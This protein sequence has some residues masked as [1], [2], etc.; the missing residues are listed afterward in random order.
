MPV[1]YNESGNLKETPDYVPEAL[2]LIPHSRYVVGHITWYSVLIMTGAALAI[3]LAER[4]QKQ[5]SLPSDTV[6]DLALRII[7][8][9]IL[10]ARIYYVLFSWQNFKDDPLSVFRVWEGG[11]AI[12]G[13]IIS[14][15]AVILIF[16][17]KRHLSVLSVCDIIVPGLA[18]AQAIGRWGNYFN[19]EAYGWALPDSSALCFFPMAVLIPEGDQNV[20]HL[21]TFF[22]ESVCDFLNFLVLLVMRKRIS[23]PKGQLFRFYI[24][25]YSAG[26]L[27]IEELRSD[28]LYS[29]SVRISQLLSFLAITILLFT[30]VLQMLDTMRNKGRKSCPRSAS[31]LLILSFLMLLP[32]GGSV[33]SLLR[34]PESGIPWK[35]I[36]LFFFSLVSVISY[37]TGTLSCLNDR[38]SACPPQP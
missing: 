14:G 6:I 32:A 24:L 25:F 22:Y 7:P 26:R 1:F 23:L 20:W 10:G 5:E 3:Y 38:R 35:L 33:F 29:G 31:L 21:A 8:F 17:R 37:L 16:C 30:L 27:V 13:G 11:L 34:F 2:P 15:L 18:L 9:G 28:S 12:Y 19:M 4:L 36:V